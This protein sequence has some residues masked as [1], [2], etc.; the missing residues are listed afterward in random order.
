MR[1][2]RKS[3]VRHNARKRHVIKRF[4]FVLSSDTTKKKET[5]VKKTLTE[6]R[7]MVLIA[8]AKRVIARLL[9]IEPQQRICVYIGAVI[10]V[11]P[12]EK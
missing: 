6:I 7:Q 9:K 1:C 4:F 10:V 11:V 12:T 5:E 8:A 2:N 3:G